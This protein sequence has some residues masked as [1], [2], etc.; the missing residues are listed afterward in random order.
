MCHRPRRPKGRTKTECAHTVCTHSALR[1][2]RWESPARGHPRFHQGDPADRTG[3]VEYCSAVHAVA[4]LTHTEPA[5]CAAIRKDPAP[6]EPIR[7]PSGAS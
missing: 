7:S 3:R 2:E 1:S 5:A 4:P 6:D